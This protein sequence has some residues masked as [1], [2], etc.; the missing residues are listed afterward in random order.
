MEFYMICI[1]L[2]MVIP[3]CNT[4]NSGEGWVEENKMLFREKAYIFYIKS[5]LFLMGRLRLPNG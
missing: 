4:K 2:S 3:Y 1:H 5:V